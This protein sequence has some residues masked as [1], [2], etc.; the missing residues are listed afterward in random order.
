MNP[1]GNQVYIDGFPALAAF[2]ASDSDRSTFLYKRFDRLASR[3]LLILQNDLAEMQSQLDAFDREDW[4][5]YQ[6]RGPVYQGA[7]QELQSWEAYKAAHGPKSDRL[8]LF[9]EL[10]KT[11]RE[12]RKYMNQTISRT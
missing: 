4:A 2:I 1:P 3:N 7:L 5:R 8:K 6:T 9:A 12:Y 11:V 10:R